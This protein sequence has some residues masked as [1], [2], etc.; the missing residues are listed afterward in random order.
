MSFQVSLPD[1]IIIGASGGGAFY[2]N[3][4]YDPASKLTYWGTGNPV[5]GY[6]ATY[7]PGDNLY[8]SSVLALDPANGKVSW[9]HQYTPNDNR[10]YDETGSHILIDTKVNG[11]D[12]KIVS[13]AGRNGFEYVFDRGNGQFLKA[14]QYVKEATWTKG[15]DPKTGKPLEYDP[16]KDFQVYAEG[17]DVNQDKRTR[18]ICPDTSGGNNYWPATYSRKT[19]LVYIPANEGCANLTPDQKSHVK[20]NFVGGTTADAGRITSSIIAVDP[21]TAQV[22]LR[23]EMPYPNFA[24][25]LSTAGGIVVTALLDG[26]IVALDDQTLEELWRLNMG[27]GFNAPPMTYAVD[28]KQYIAIASGLFRNARNKLSRSPEMKNVSSATMIFVFGL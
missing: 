8:T 9:F 11:E 15:I 26:T 18:R 19:S 22:K 21:T 6:D 16:G 14:G 4:S 24:G 13:H 23:H 7:R 1:H 27:T 3:G 25:T 2:V 20:G 10:D 28:G 17:V 5:P 12:R